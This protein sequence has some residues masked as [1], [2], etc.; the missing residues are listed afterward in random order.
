MS[1]LPLLKPWQSEPPVTS[2][3]NLS[4]DFQVALG[5]RGGVLG[6]KTFDAVQPGVHERRNDFVRAV[7]AGMRHHRQPAGLVNQLDALQGG[8]LG[9]GHPGGPV[10]FEK[11]LER[12]VQIFD[13]TGFHQRAGD[14]RAAGRFAVGQRKNGFRLERDVQGIEAGDH[15]A[16]AV[17]A[18][19]LE[20]GEF[21][22]AAFDSACP[23]NN[24]GYAVRCRCIRRSVPCRG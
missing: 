12:L 22:R 14:V 1:G 5:H 8:H 16:D 13:Q 10:L 4:G 24:R 11:S 15:F 21:H 19:G 17:L 23:G 2:R 18:D 9:L 7:Q 6:V 3:L 20:L